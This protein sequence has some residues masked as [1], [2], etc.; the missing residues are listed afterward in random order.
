MSRKVKNQAKKENKRTKLDQADYKAIYDMMQ[1]SED[2]NTNSD[3]ELSLLS[4]P[5]PQAQSITSEA[6]LRNDK[7]TNWWNDDDYDYREAENK[8]ESQLFSLNSFDQC[9]P[10]PTSTEIESSPS[11]TLLCS[12]TVDRGEGKCDL[13]S[14]IA[15]VIAKL[16]KLKRDMHDTL[17]QIAILEV[18][19]DEISEAQDISTNYTVSTI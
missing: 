4:P 1:N 13:R 5:A 14:D 7:S 16:T 9:S 2:N 18:R 12:I 8:Q 19:M 6:S 17:M 3:E 10:Q 11:S 15:D